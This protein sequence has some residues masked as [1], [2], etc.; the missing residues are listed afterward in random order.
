VLEVLR[1]RIPEHVPVG[2]F[3]GWPHLVGRLLLGLGMGWRGALWVD[4]DSCSNLVVRGMTGG[5]K[6]V[7][8]WHACTH[9]ATEYSP[10]QLRF[11]LRDLKGGTALAQFGYL[12]HAMAPVADN[13]L[14]AADLLT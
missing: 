7:F 11:C 3:C 5:A 14:A 13:V 9:L 10:D 12:P 6:S 4:L 8:F 2:E 1:R